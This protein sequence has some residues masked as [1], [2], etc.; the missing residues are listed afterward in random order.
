[1]RYKT[2]GADTCVP[3]IACLT[4]YTSPTLAAVLSCHN[5]TL[6]VVYVTVTGV[7]LCITGFC[8]L[9]SSLVL[10]AVCSC[11]VVSWRIVYFSCVH[12]LS[13]LYISTTYI[14]ILH[15]H[16]VVC[17][18]V[19]P[20]SRKPK[21]LNSVSIFCLLAGTVYL[22]REGCVWVWYRVEVNI[23][24][25]HEGSIMRRPWSRKGKEHPLRPTFVIVKKLVCVI[26]CMLR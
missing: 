17:S 11:S 13:C 3:L 15:R 1:V 21:F 9:S 2:R 5:S 6:Y 10:T 22:I 18:C 24:C 16:V 12:N 19:L 26:Y 20:A 8:T 23:I 14:G 7:C 4:L 25:D